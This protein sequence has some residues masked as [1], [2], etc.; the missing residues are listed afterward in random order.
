MAAHRMRLKTVL[1]PRR[2]QKDLVDIPRDVQ[3]QLKII[4]VERMEEVLP[5]AL[6]D[7]PPPPPK[8]KRTRKPRKKDAAPEPAEQSAQ[9]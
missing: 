4:L 3:R 5:H 9:A 7:A 6:L 1:I 2:N 8:P